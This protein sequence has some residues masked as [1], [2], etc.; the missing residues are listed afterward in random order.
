MIDKACFMTG[1]KFCLRV[2]N[3][4]TILISCCSPDPTF[5]DVWNLCQKMLESEANVPKTAV[6][7]MTT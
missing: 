6:P 3:T 1:S 5:S 4:F 2:S 7:Q